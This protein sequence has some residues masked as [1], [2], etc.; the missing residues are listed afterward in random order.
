MSCGYLY[1]RI[2]RLESQNDKLKCRTH[3]LY[4]EISVLEAQLNK[5]TGILLFGLSVMAAVLFTK[6]QAIQPQAEQNSH[7]P[8]SSPSTTPTAASGS[9]VNC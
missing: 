3:R 9:M 5:T 8:S 4:D 7:P 2:N 6:Y 1:A